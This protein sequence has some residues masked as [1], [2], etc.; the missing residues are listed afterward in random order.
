MS[1]N[2]STKETKVEFLQ[3]CLTIAEALNCPALVTLNGRIGL[4]SGLDNLQ[5][6]GVCV[7]LEEAKN[8]LYIK[9]KVRGDGVL[10]IQEDMKAYK[11]DEDYNSDY[12]T[13]NPRSMREL[14]GFN[15]PFYKELTEVFESQFLS[16]DF[17]DYLYPG[18]NC[19]DEFIIR[20]ADPVFLK[21]DDTPEWSSSYQPLWKIYDSIKG[22]LTPF[23]I[24]VIEEFS[25][26]PC[27]PKLFELTPRKLSLEFC[28]ETLN[29]FELRNLAKEILRFVVENYPL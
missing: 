13:K 14:L 9:Y 2:T 27:D 5:R 25:K 11:E 26:A 21:V 24:K 10:S 4:I 1:E 23:A 20:F 28:Y 8:T 16:L 18:K 29:T 3:S 7:F 12:T 17:V 6:E 19:N 15:D 22:D